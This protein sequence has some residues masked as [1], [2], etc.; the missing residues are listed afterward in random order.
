MK[1]FTFLLTAASAALAT[2][3]TPIVSSYGT[4]IP[5]PGSYSQTSGC[6]GTPLATWSGVPED[7]FCQATPGVVSL[8]ITVG[9]QTSCQ[10][11]VFA[12]SN[13]NGINGNFTGIPV[14]NGC[15]TISW[16]MCSSVVIAIVR[17][18][19]Q[20]GHLNPEKKRTY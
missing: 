8:N 13:C 16:F 12:T 14:V 9:T 19:G 2:Q 20:C 1:L 11:D 3:V 7:A 4:K 17:H 10:M 18:R 15:Y 6:Y 5:S